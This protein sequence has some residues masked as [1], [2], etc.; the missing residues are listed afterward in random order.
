MAYVFKTES[1]VLKTSSFIYEQFL[2]MS[3]L[4]EILNSAWIHGSIKIFHPL[5]YCDDSM[6]LK[7]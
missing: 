2:A 3:G 4:R 1:Y 6:T 7:Y 5:R